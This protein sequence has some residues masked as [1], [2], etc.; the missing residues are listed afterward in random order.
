MGLDVFLGAVVTAYEAS[1][2]CEIFNAL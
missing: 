2:A 1:G